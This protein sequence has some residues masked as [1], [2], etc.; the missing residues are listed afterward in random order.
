MNRAMRAV[1]GL[2]VAVAM[3]AA[4]PVAAQDAKPAKEKVKVAHFHLTGELTETPQDDS[5]GLM[6]D[7]ITSLKD[8][9]ER[10]EKARKDSAVKAM[11][12]TY[13]GMPFGFAQAEEVAAELARF[14]ADKKP[15]LVHIAGEAMAVNVGLYSLIAGASTLSV[16]PTSDVWLTGFTASPVYLKGLLDKIGVTADFLHAGAY[17]SAGETF[18]RTG[19]SDE[20][21]ENMNW[22]VDGLYA[23]VLN[24]IGMSR[25]MTPEKVRDIVD[26]GPYTDEKAKAAGLVDAIEYRDQFLAKVK[27]TFGPDTEIDNRYGIKKGPRIDPG[28]PF[29]FL[30]LLSQASSGSRKSTKDAV[31][32]VYVEGMILSGYGH[33]SPFGGSGGAAY[34]GDIT[35]AL[36]KAAED[37]SVKAVV[38]RVDS[39]GGSA[40]ASESILRGTKL[41]KDAGKPMVV[42]MGNVAASGGYYVSCESDRIF[43]SEGTITASIGVV[44]GKMITLGMWD[45]LGVNFLDYERGKRA[46]LLST[47]RAWTDEEKKILEGWMNGVYDDFKGHVT[48]GREGKLKKPIDD[49]A[50]GRVYTGKQALELGLVDEIGG[51]LEA[52]KYAAGKAGI[53]SY[54]LRAVPEPKN[55]LDALFGDLSGEGDRNSDLSVTVGGYVNRLTGSDAT[56]GV[57][58]ALFPALRAMDPVRARAVLRAVGRLELLNGQAPVMVMPEEIVI[59]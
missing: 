22:L 3:T 14:K 59:H 54:E 57:W 49:M 56:A 30:S 50:G 31:G 37:K 46:G 18:T 47:S 9:L 55:F 11:I 33:L 5:L 41:V 39:P 15:V 26:N 58:Q 13:D 28:N 19:P 7:S 8:L 32:V 29:A 10:M 1:L 4:A 23:G 17:K 53:E 20:A 36:K 25:G 45:K 27:E 2:V 51:L 35:A 34:S 24:R 38:L 6:G 40:L 48:K 52:A 12:L 16:E 21:K 42:S 43:A 44:M